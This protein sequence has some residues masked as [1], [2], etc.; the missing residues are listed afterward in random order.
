MP[1]CD[2]WSVVFQRSTRSFPRCWRAGHRD[3]RRG[4][5]TPGWSG[6]LPGGLIAVQE[7]LPDAEGGHVACAGVPAFESRAIMVARCSLSTRVE[8]RLAGQTGRPFPLSRR[9]HQLEF[10]GAGWPPRHHVSMSPV[11]ST[12]IGSRP[13]GRGL[14][15]ACRPGLPAGIGGIVLSCR[16]TVTCSRRKV[17]G[18]LG[19]AAENAVLIAVAWDR[20]V[21]APVYGPALLSLWEP[22][23]FVGS[24]E[25]LR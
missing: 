11:T 20:S 14:I 21:P 5:S 22:G 24:R 2:R 13:G 1:R 25:R 23:A 3:P 16:D 7:G 12:M 8:D 6:R 19:E 17:L 18:L 9:L 15:Y 10:S 4:S